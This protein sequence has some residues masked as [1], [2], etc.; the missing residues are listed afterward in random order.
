MNAHTQVLPKQLALGLHEYFFNCTVSNSAPDSRNSGYFTHG[1]DE[2]ELR[3]LLI[4]EE[5]CFI[6]YGFCNYNL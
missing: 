3:I 6:T 4:K 2:Y 1:L 5:R